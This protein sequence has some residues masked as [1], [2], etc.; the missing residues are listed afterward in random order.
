[1]VLCIEPIL[2][3]AASRRRAG[4]HFR[5]RAAGAGHRDRLRGAVRSAPSHVVGKDS[6]DQ[7]SCTSA[8]CPTA[9]TRPSTAISHGIESHGRRGRCRTARRL[10]RL[11][12]ARTGATTAD[13]AVLAGADAGFDTIVIWV[14]DPVGPRPARS[15]TPGARA[16][17]VV[18]LERPRFAGRC[19]SV[20]YPNFNHGVYMAEH[21]A[22]LLAPGARVAVVGGPDVVDDIE[23]LL[24]NQARPGRRRAWS[25][26]TTRRTPG[27]RT[28]PT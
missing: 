19:D 26:S 28:P 14:I 5:V 9:P 10:R 25:R 22:S 15:A 11:R 21:L 1:M 12:R 13:R 2:A 18:S 4:R 20:V 27:T 23:L 6:C 17:P 3:P 8:P 24:G 16:C 7:R